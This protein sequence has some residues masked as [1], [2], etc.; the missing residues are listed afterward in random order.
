MGLMTGL[1]LSLVQGGLGLPVL[2]TSQSGTTD[3]RNGVVPGTLGV[4]ASSDP[5]ARTTDM[6]ATRTLDVYEMA[7]L[8]G[9]PRQAI[10]AAV[11]SLIEAGVLRVIG[12]AAS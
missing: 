10:E 5:R 2:S 1:A 11:V 3:F 7:Y 9:G 6:T 12:R 8:A 4:T